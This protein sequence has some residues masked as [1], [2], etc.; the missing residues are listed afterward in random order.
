M[1]DLRARTKPKKLK[2][3]L[4]IQDTFKFLNALT[5]LAI[6][7]G[8]NFHPPP[9]RRHELRQMIVTL[10]GFCS[11]TECEGI[12]KWLIEDGQEQWFAKTQIWL[13]LIGAKRAVAYFDAVASAFPKGKIPKDD[14]ARADL[15]LDSSELSAK[16]RQIDLD[17]KDC[18]AELAEGLR[19]Y[20]QQ[21]FE[22]F[23]KELEDEENRVV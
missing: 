20:I 10:N 15:L 17:Y 6:P 16:L 9:E 21:H 11:Y 7:P 4:A 12:W 23:R 5:N 19:Q 22:L 2:E 14:E 1:V 18:F 8:T 13:G 3:I